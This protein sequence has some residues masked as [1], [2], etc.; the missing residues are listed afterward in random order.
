MRAGEAATSHELK[1]IQATV[2]PVSTAVELYTEFESAV[3][4]NVVLKC[5]Q[6]A[7]ASGFMPPVTFKND[8]VGNHHAADAVIRVMAFGK[9][10]GHSYTYGTPTNAV[11]EFLKC[12]EAAAAAASAANDGSSQAGFD[13]KTAEVMKQSMRDLN[14][15]LH[16][17]ADVGAGTQNMIVALPNQVAE[18]VGEA[19]APGIAA[20][21]SS[22]GGCAIDIKL[23]LETVAK[24]ALA[25]QRV[26]ELTEALRQKTKEVDRQEK[27]TGDKTK[28]VNALKRMD[29]DRLKTI[30][31]QARENAELREEIA[32]HADEVAEQQRLLRRANATIDTLHGAEWCVTVRNDS[33]RRRVES[34]AAAEAS[35][36]SDEEDAHEDED[37]DDN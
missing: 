17:V 26:V 9:K 14:E 32:Q 10:K 33:K 25:E 16:K 21:G 7:G 37:E 22:I 27:K 31:E 28:E 15:G 3:S 24:C 20:V 6:D 29:A 8:P 36:V 5:L 18:A 1:F 34:G 2:D 11:A 23:V 13:A 12:A 35:T 4:Q 30:A 19:V